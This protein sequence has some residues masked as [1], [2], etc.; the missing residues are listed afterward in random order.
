MKQIVK[1][2]IICKKYK[3]FISII[4]NYLEFKKENMKQSPVNTVTAFMTFHF[5]IFNSVFTCSFF[6]HDAQIVFP[7]TPFSVSQTIIQWVIFKYIAPPFHTDN[8]HHVPPC[9]ILSVVLKFVFLSFQY[10]SHHSHVRQPERD[11]SYFTA[12]KAATQKYHPCHQMIVPRQDSKAFSTHFGLLPLPAAP[13]AHIQHTA[14]ARGLLTAPFCPL[15]G[16]P[17]QQLP[18]Q[19]ET[20]FSS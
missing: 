11:Y 1:Y 4:S 10:H 18:E 9:I 17:C 12:Q 6:S 16:R 5:H 3:A 14:R 8:H 2:C 20:S 19:S 15:L 7:N 13:E